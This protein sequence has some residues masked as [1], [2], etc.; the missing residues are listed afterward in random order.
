MNH[1]VLVLPRDVLVHM[2]SGVTC[3]QSGKVKETQKSGIN[4]YPAK[5]QEK[6][7]GGAEIIY[8]LEDK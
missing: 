2:D 5:A 1:E 3:V 7:S 4:G 6:S 8:L